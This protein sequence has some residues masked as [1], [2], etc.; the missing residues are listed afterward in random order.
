MV[1]VFYLTVVEYCTFSVVYSM[2]GMES[3]SPMALP[4]QRKPSVTT[5]G[6]GT[7]KAG[8]RKLSFNDGT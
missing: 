3:I 2:A 7:V 5:T 4:L 8:F 6:I 1:K